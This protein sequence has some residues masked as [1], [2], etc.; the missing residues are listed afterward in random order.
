[1]TFRSILVLL[2]ASVCGI[3]AVV[4]VLNTGGFSS[5][6]SADTTPVVVAA[7]EIR[8][9]ETIT[10][11]MVKVVEWPKGFVPPGALVK[12]EQAIDH[13]ALQ[14][15]MKD[16]PLLELKVATNAS[17][18]GL[19][20]LIQDGMRAF[21]ILT[22]SDA[23][24]V[25]GFILPGNRVDVVLAV[26]GHDEASGGGTATTLL[27]NIEVL[28]VGQRLEAPRENKV[29]PKE[30]RS[31]TLSVTPDQAAKLSLAQTR[32]TLHLSLRSDVDEQ[33]APVET[34]TLKELRFMQLAGANKPEDA[35]A[36]ETT[37]V[38]APAPETP[39]EPQRR[40]IRVLRGTTS[41]QLIISGP[42]FDRS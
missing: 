21:T 7:V 24:G 20:P 26:S 8:R 2:L 29:E 15:I 31:I 11:K 27:Q 13:T 35:P 10:P 16:E 30:M 33:T 14:G 3:C 17:G 18:H 39:R 12:T 37:P 6:G 9:G 38:A 36:P 1:M 22:P 42:Q 28:A 41:D 5:S 40:F 19:A 4:A 23:S 25:A 34:V 32:G